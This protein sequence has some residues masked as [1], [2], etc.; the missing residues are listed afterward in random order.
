MGESKPVRKFT[1]AELYREVAGVA[2]SLK[3][4]GIEPAD[5]V[6][7]YMPNMPETIIAMLAGASMGAT[8]SSC[9]PDFGT[10]GVLDR[11]GQ[12]EPKV[13]FTTDG[14]FYKGKHID[15]LGRVARILRE[16][17][18]VKQVVVVPYASE[19]PDISGIPNAVLYE[20]FVSKESEPQ[21]D[22]LQLPFDHPHYIMYS[23]GTT[24][25][26]KCMVQSAGGVLIQ[27][28][29]E[30]VLHVDLKREDNLFY[31]TT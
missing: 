4:L 7:G 8:W 20:D 2:S 31:F 16:L 30:H 9:S 12:I 24:G 10:Q 21:I 19:K 6:V 29:K 3:A 18:M 26:S 27:Q 22:F 28:A 5:R 17:P 13:L 11:F 1:Y 15:N 25:P 14:Y 23:S